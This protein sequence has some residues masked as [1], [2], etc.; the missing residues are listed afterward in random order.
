MKIIAINIG[1]RSYKISCVAGEENK[2]NK[3]TAKLNQRYKKLETSLGNKASADMILVIIGLMLE[4]EV[5]TNNLADSKELKNEN[6]SKIKDI[7]TRIDGIIENL[8]DLQ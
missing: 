4:D 3:L 2:I 6:K 7:S 1:N 5:A 8:T